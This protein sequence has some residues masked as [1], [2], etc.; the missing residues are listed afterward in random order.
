MSR[1]LFRN[2]NMCQFLI[3]LMV[4]PVKFG[5]MR[6]AVDIPANKLFRHGQQVPCF[7]S[8]LTPSQKLFAKKIHFLDS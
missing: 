2:E 5:R 3:E 6:N 4:T 1:E 8:P 7:F